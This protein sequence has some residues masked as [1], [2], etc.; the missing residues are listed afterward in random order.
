MIVRQIR[1]TVSDLNYFCFLK[2]RQN[3]QK[4][5]HQNTDTSFP[6][7]ENLTSHPYNPTHS[8]EIPQ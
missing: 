1:L 2:H 7:Q 3:P 8:E 4:S 6:N 5:T